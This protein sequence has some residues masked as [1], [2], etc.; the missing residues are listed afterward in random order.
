MLSIQRVSWHENSLK[1]SAQFCHFGVL[2]SKNIH[3]ALSFAFA[4]KS[5]STIRKKIAA[6]A[7]V[8]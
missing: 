7:A 8:K 2:N 6:L 3:L 4:K 5:R 1:K